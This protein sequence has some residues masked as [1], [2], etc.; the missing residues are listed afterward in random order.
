MH[1]SEKSSAKGWVSPSD[2][3]GACTLLAL[4]LSPGAANL[5]MPFPAHRPASCPSRS[6]SF[7]GSSKAK[8]TACSSSLMHFPLCSQSS[9]PALELPTRRAH[10]LERPPLV[11]SS[12]SEPRLQDQ[13]YDR[14]VSTPTPETPAPDSLLPSTRS[15]G[16]NRAPRPG[17]APAAPG[18]LGHPARPAGRSAAGRSGRRRGGAGCSGPGPPGCSPRSAPLRRAVPAARRAAAGASRRAAAA[19]PRS[20]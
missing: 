8:T 3:T 16:H 12:A 7:R 6:G 19:P 14:C 1:L 10:L 9:G 2:G 11:T 20:L 15:E 5:S 13:A 4:L 17:R 18:R